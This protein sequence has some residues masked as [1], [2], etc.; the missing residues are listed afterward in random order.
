MYLE[1]I[2]YIIFRVNI[3]LMSFKAQ[4]LQNPSFITCLSQAL[5]TINK[6]IRFNSGGGW[7]GKTSTHFPKPSPVQE[8]TGK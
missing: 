4:L 8:I 3:T 1:F 2:S 7:L 5:S 6:I